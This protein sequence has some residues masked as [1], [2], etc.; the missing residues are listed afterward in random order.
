MRLSNCPLLLVKVWVHWECC[1][2]VDCFRIN[3]DLCTFIN[4]HSAK[5]QINMTQS[6]FSLVPFCWGSPSS[7]S[8]YYW[9]H[10]LVCPL[11]SLFSF[12]FSSWSTHLYFFPWLSASSLASDIL[13]Q[14]WAPPCW[15]PD[16]SPPP[17]P[18]Q[19]MSQN[20][21]YHP[22]ASSAPNFLSPLPFSLLTPLIFHTSDCSQVCLL[23]FLCVVPPPPPH[24]FFFFPH[25]SSLFSNEPFRDCQSSASPPFCLDMQARKGVK[26]G[27][28]VTDWFVWGSFKQLQWREQALKRGWLNL[29]RF[30]FGWNVLFRP[31]WQF[32]KQKYIHIYRQTLS[33]DFLVIYTITSCGLFK[34]LSELRATQEHGFVVGHFTSCY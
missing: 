31:T 23:K 21:K 33:H 10:L 4:K 27:G 7:S 32:A 16:C 13:S 6:L 2:V 26:D 19:S 28:M 1:T 24:Y 3:S 25:P 30:I 11:I 5:Q 22:F 12:S 18:L 14:S 17:A 29:K 20:I 8:H 15:H 9:T 34:P